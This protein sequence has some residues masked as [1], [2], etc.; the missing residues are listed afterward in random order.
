MAIKICVN[1][2]VKQYGDC[3]ALK[4]VSFCAEGPGLIV[5]LGASGSGKTTFLNQIGLLDSFDDG[6]ITICG[7]RVGPRNQVDRC[8]I[9]RNSF[10]SY[11]F[12]DDVLLNHLSIENNILYPVWLTGEVHGETLVEQYTKRL[13]VNDLLKRKPH[14]VSRGQR[15]RVALIRAMMGTRK[16]L[17]AD[18]PT[19]NL[20]NE[21]SIKIFEILKELSRERMVIVATH[22]AE[23]AN[24]YADRV[25]TFVDGKIVKDTGC[26]LN[27]KVVTL[28]PTV[29]PRLSWKHIAINAVADIR[30]RRSNLFKVLLS[31]VLTLI[32]LLLTFSAKSIADNQLTALEEDYFYKNLLVLT[33]DKNYSEEAAIMG[34]SSQGRYL[35]DYRIATQMEGVDE[36]V[37]YFD[38]YP[39]SLI[40][41]LNSEELTHIT[42]VKDNAFFRNKIDSMGLTNKLFSDKNNII[43]ALDVAK[44]LF[45]DEYEYYLGKEIVLSSGA[46]QCNVRI[47]GFNTVK[48]INKHYQSYLWEEFHSTVAAAEALN[49]SKVNAVLVCS[50]QNCTNRE[51]EYGANYAVNYQGMGTI[52]SITET[53]LP[54]PAAGRTPK[55]SGEVMLSIPFLVEEAPS[56]FGVYVSPQSIVDE[57]ALIDRILGQ[58]LFLVGTGLANATIVGVYDNNAGLYSDMICTSDVSEGLI[59]T[60]LYKMEIYMDEDAS[61]EMLKQ[62][63]SRIG[64][65]VEHPYENYESGISGRFS[66]VRVLLTVLTIVMCIISI[67]VISSFSSNMINDGRKGIG[68]I[69]AMG[70]NSRIVCK[71]YA[72]ETVLVG[73]LAAVTCTLL[74]LTLKVLVTC[75]ALR[76]Y[77]LGHLFLAVEPVHL[78][79]VAIFSVVL[80]VISAYPSLRRINKIMPKDAIY[81][82][83]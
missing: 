15:Q 46:Y 80:F 26:C 81:T 43:L 16:I 63:L 22:D 41:G 8:D 27:S 58:E 28:E 42:L 72:L 62:E 83:N 34:Y 45:G 65:V 55:D 54:A 11:M 5:L 64:F 50:E 68:I 74:V 3:T 59:Q 51:G 31:S 69:K 71:I 47:V 29:K 6:E 33:S 7:H 76:E 25:L 77:E 61:V 21:N 73:I 53:D 32:V 30:Q 37:C 67:S 14:Q 18:E 9:I 35:E 40:F 20:D 56:L 49:G 4:Q 39:Y 2:V 70:A 52:T 10:I 66:S 48:D 1:R 19:G 44:A 82:M 24:R 23:L 38:E 36:F 78:L 75:T 60:P 79:A 12:Q 57:P 13:E 17:L